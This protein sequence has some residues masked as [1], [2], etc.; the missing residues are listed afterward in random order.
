V[1]TS[2]SAAK[3]D[4]DSVAASID[5][6]RLR[7]LLEASDGDAEETFRT[8]QSALSG[9]IEKVRLDALGAAIDDFDFSGA[10]QKL[11]EIAQGIELTQRKANG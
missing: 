11:D 10:L 3:T 7:V 4:L 5:I 8:L 6:A 9:H 1:S 2:E